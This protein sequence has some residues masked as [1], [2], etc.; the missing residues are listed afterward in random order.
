MKLAKFM[1]FL[2][3]L[4]CSMPN[5]KQSMQNNFNFDKNLSL[6]D[7]KK[8]IIK[9]GKESNFPDINDLNE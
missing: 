6:D 4:S 3:F 2:L 7:F 8:I 9:Y 1:F 5:T